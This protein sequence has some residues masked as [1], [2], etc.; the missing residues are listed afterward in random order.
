MVHNKIL[1]LACLSLTSLALF[2]NDPVFVCRDSAGKRSIQDSPCGATESTERR[3]QALDLPDKILSQT[4]APAIREATRPSAPQRHKV[5]KRAPGYDMQ[6]I[7]ECREHVHRLHSIDA[8]YRAGYTAAEEERLR[9]GRKETGDK[10]NE[11]CR[12]VVPQRFWSNGRK[13]PDP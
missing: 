10:I 9:R 1:W 3:L 7:Q 13:S 4:P 6:R 8:R 12:N 5:A 2:A 11:R